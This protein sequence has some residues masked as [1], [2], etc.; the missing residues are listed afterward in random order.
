MFYLI[1]LTWALVQNIVGFLILQYMKLTH[2]K[3]TIT[4]YKKSYVINTYN[5]IGGGVSLGMF[6]FLQEPTQ[7]DIMH[8]YGHTIQSMILGPA[9]LLL[10]GLPSFLWSRFGKYE[11]D[12]Y[13][14]FPTEKWA[15]KLGKVGPRIE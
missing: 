1:N 11:I 3:Y 5:F 12:Q 9:Y 2:K 7:T 15:D 4:R 13:Y 10:I 8:E 6:I 14:K